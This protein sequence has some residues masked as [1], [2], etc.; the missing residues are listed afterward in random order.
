[1]CRPAKSLV[2]VLERGPFL[3]GQRP[4]GED[5]SQSGGGQVSGGCESG[6]G[7]TGEGARDPVPGEGAVTTGQ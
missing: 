3:A 2:E 7:W 4:D 5:E 6:H 1:M